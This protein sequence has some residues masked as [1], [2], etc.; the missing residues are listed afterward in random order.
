MINN[1]SKFIKLELR[2]KLRVIENKF[3]FKIYPH[4]IKNNLIDKIKFKVIF[5]FILNER[6]KKI[7]KFYKNNIRLDLNKKHNCI[8]TFPR[9]GTHYVQTVINSYYEIF[10]DIGAGNVK[11]DGI[12]DKY[13]QLTYS[14]N[15]I[16]DLHNGINFSNNY[17]FFNLS[18]EKKKNII[19]I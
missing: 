17:N 11:Y 16:F 19:R 10:L 1:L 14:L 8:I 18:T 12:N 5:F 15:E 4:Y 3:N 13:Y 9:S 2:N 7:K 6:L